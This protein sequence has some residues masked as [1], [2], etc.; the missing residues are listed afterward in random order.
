MAQQGKLGLEVLTLENK[1]KELKADLADFAIEKDLFKQDDEV[2][3]RIKEIK[4]LAEQ[5]V[6]KKTEIDLLK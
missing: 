6:I 1:V 3:A 4:D 5:I 2:N